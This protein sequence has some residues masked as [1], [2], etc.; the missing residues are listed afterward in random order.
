MARRSLSTQC[1][2]CGTRM[3][4]TYQCDEQHNPER[5]FKLRA[6][7]PACQTNLI[8]LNGEVHYDE[9]QLQRGRCHADVVVNTSKATRPQKQAKSV[10]PISMFQ[11]KH[12]RVLGSK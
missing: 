8:I 10:V 1:C 4:L 9:S 3:R 6:A 5:P 7:C 11:G 12:H 2:H